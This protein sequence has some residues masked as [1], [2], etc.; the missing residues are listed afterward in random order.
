MKNK[1]KRRATLVDVAERAGVSRATASLVIRNSPLVATATRARVELAMQELGY[2]HNLGA[3]RLRADKSRIVGLVVP[4]LTNPFFAE[5]LAGVEE[6]INAAG[7]VV[8]LANSGDNAERQ[9]NLMRRMREHGVDGMIVCPAAGSESDIFSAPAGWQIPFVQVLRHVDEKTDYVGPDYTGGMSAA[10]EYLAALGHRNIAFAVQG[11]VHSA[12][13]ERLSG[14][15]AAMARRDLDPT[16]I[17]R[18]PTPLAEIAASADRLLQGP[19][20]PTATICFNDVIAFGLSSGF[21]DRNISI[22]RDHSILGFDDVMD[23]EAIR[24]RL[25]SVSTKPAM[26]GSNAA[27]CLLERLQD[28]NRAPLRMVTRTELI[29]RESCSSIRSP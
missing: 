24:P 14:F 25:T 29:V 22:P 23:A 10:V 1:S 26:L 15:T 16:K 2:V 3:A 27:T 21:Y 11:S 8:L 7:L 13:Q 19:R 9:A 28:R 12:Y 6:I 20:A 18:F 5:L 4:N 17:L